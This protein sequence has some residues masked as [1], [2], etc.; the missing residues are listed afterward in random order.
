LAEVDG[1]LR[2]SATSHIAA[3]AP[4]GEAE[5]RAITAFGPPDVVAA[6]FGCDVISIVQNRL[7]VF[8]RRTRQWLED[9]RW[10]G[11]A[12]AVVPIGVILGA[13]S[14][15]G[16]AFGAN[17]REF[18]TV[19]PFML[20]GS[21]LCLLYISWRRPSRSSGI[22]RRWAPSEEVHRPSYVFGEGLPLWAAHLL[23]GVPCYRILTAGPSGYNFGTA[24]YLI[25]LL[26]FA[27]WATISFLLLGGVRALGLRVPVWLVTVVPLFLPLLATTVV[28]DSQ[29]SIG[30]RLCIGAVIVMA[31]LFRAVPASVYW[32]RIAKEMVDEE[33]TERLRWKT[34]ATDWPLPSRLPRWEQRRQM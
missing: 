14:A 6:S 13:S 27:F 26:Q 12:A 21:Y 5:R 28:F 1:H 30:L 8:N 33:L 17:W 15:I 29:S 20:L 24:D 4:G 2:E 3:G 16:A 7:W 25:L 23:W 32:S 18:G 34:V 11:P 22:D 10:L 9:H 19:S 31:A